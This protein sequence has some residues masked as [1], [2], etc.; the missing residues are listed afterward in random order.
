MR[1]ACLD[2][3]QKRGQATNKWLSQWREYEICKSLNFNEL[4]NVTS[5]HQLGTAPAFAV[6]QNTAAEER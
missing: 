4:R 2:P 3:V 5:F 1:G 6:E